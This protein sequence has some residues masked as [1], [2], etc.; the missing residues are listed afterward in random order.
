[1]KNHFLLY[2]SLILLLAS[3]CKN[4][5]TDNYVPPKP[6]TVVDS[7]AM[8]V[9]NKTGELNHAVF[10]VAIVVDSDVVQPGIYDVRAAYG[11]NTADGKFS[12]PHGGEKYKP[13]I[14]KAAEPYRYVVGFRI[15]KDTTFY[16][17]F[18]VTAQQTAIGMKY[19]KSYTFE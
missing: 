18:E 4:D 2:S 10:S 11:N 19:I 17:Y 5:P 1:M 7:M 16:E 12:M 13:V 3:G 9:E 14:K 15:P 8:P 6:G